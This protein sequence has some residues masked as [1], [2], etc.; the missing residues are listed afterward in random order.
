MSRLNFDS[1]G[2]LSQIEGISV[3][4]QTSLKK[5]RKRD[6][7]L[8]NSN[9]LE[10]LHDSSPKLISEDIFQKTYWNLY[11]DDKEISPLKFSNN[12][13]QEDVVKEIVDL[14]NNGKKIIFLHGTCGSGKSAIA[15]NIARVLGTASI[16]VPIKNLQKQYEED[17]MGSKYLLKNNG[18]KM[19]IAMITGRDNHDSIINPGVS[20]ADQNLPEN[21]KITEKNYRQLL[22]YYKENPFVSSISNPELKN[23]RR[24]SVAPSNPYW[25]PILPADF[26]INILKDAKKIRYLGADG[27]EYLF[28]HRKK[29]CSYYDQHLAYTQADVIIFNAAKYNSELSMGR[30]PVTEVEIID[31]ADEYLDSLFQ[32]DELNLTRFAFA[33]TSL[34]PDSFDAKEIISKILELLKLEEQNK[35]ATGVDESKV[36]KISE[37]KIKKILELLKSNKELSAEITIDELNYSNKVLEAAKKFDSLD[38]IYL[39]FRKDEENLYAKLVSTNLSGKIQDLIKKS[40][41]LIFMSGTL[42]SKNVLNKIFGITDYEVVEAETVNQGSIEIMMTGKEF[43]CKYSNF[44]SNKYS[45]EDYLSS[46]STCLDKAKSP[47]LIQVNAFQ[48]LPS[49]EE[50]LSYDLNNLM[51]R[52]KLRK[53]QSD[54]KLGK[55]VSIFKSGLSDFLFTT[56][57]TRGVD[58]PGDMCNSIIFTKYPNPNI[59]DTFWKILKQTHPESFWEFYKDKARR[60]FLQRIYRAIRSTEDHVYILSPDYRVLEEVKR[61]QLIKGL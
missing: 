31:E 29:G 59:S 10:F 58:F 47:V 40:K 27:R 23:I 54:D 17:Y 6:S 56:K 18:E 49:E 14:I 35:K 33:L 28:Y 12:K 21:I 11:S 46:F 3:E 37:T 13:T 7:N 30:K 60:E 9:S 38:D 15:L 2:N 57:C 45:R 34:T 20:C 5:E 42:H 26:E 44:N 24:M 53:I 8:K 43:D 39:T 41:S 55:N 51:T 61:L 36:F 19:K 22:K 48:D 50:K 1:S 32:Q 4:T 52:E 25:S 16:V